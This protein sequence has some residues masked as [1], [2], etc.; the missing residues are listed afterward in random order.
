MAIKFN[1]SK[2]FTVGVELELQLVDKKTLALT[3][4]SDKILSDVGKD[5]SLSPAP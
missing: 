5:P 1:A 3:G 2:D 4:T